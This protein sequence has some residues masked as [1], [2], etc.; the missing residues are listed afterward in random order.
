MI[1]LGKKA[2]S[3]KEGE[4]I[5]KQLINKGKAFN[6]FLEIVELQ[7][8]DLNYINSPDKYS[9]PK[10]SNKIRSVKNGFIKEMNTYQIGMAS[11]E[12][13]A[14]RH[15]KDDIIDPKAGI[16]LYK[17]IGDSVVKGE[18]ICELYSD[19]KNKIKSAEQ[20]MI[21]ALKFSKRKPQIPKLIKKVIH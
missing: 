20:I 8:G 10:Y 11:L 5:A 9:K 12:L 14:G 4:Q 1:H 3:I 2:K 7:G 18:V 16:I 17:K 15:T 6:K 21:E 19:S 13:G